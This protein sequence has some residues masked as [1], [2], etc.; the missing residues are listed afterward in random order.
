MVDSVSSWNGIQQ[1]M[2]RYENT[3]VDVDDGVDGVVVVV[4]DMMVYQCV[5]PRLRWTRCSDCVGPRGVG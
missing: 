2:I 4:V 1:L 3:N 5:G